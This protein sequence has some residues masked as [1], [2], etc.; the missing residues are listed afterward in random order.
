M[1]LR[2][3]LVALLL[4]GVFL[5]WGAWKIEHRSKEPAPPAAGAPVSGCRTAAQKSAMPHM[6][7]CRDMGV[8]WRIRSSD[9]CRPA[10]SDAPPASEFVGRYIAC[11]VS[12]GDPVLAGELTEHPKVAP[13]SGKTLYLL[14]LAKGEEASWNAGNRVDLFPGP[15]AVV[16]NAEVIAV[17]CDSDCDAVLQLTPAEVELLKYTDA[18]KLKRVFH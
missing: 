11:I 15:T 13:A 3:K 17:I 7:A 4:W 16:S 14:A 12:A 18:L 8:N 10:P 9:L 6:V 5:A 2:V 1:R